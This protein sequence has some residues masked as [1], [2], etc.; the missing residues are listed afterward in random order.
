MEIKNISREDGAFERDSCYLVENII[1]ED[2]RKVLNALMSLEFAGS[3]RPKRMVHG[4]DELYNSATLCVINQALLNKIKEITKEPGLYPT[5]GFYR[6]YYKGQALGKHVDR[7][8]CQ[9]TISICLSESDDSEWPL[10]IE[11]EKNDITYKGHTKP[12]DAIIYTGEFLPHWR[13]ECPKKWCKQFFLH[14]STDSKLKFDPNGGGKNMMMVR[15][16][17]ESFVEQD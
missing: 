2:C 14:Y 1:S 13:D 11:D 17:I 6:K 8:E 5:Y 4:S 7:P 9:L 10:Y 12:G 3:V 15:N 16:L